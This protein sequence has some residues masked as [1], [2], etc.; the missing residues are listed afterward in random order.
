LDTLALG[1]EAGSGSRTLAD[2]IF[3]RLNGDKETQA[4]EEEGWSF[5]M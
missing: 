4:M 2:I 3:D 1:A 5:Q